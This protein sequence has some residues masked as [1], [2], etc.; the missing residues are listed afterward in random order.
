MKRNADPVDAFIKAA[1]LKH[2]L[3][4]RGVSVRQLRAAS[5]KMT[6]AFGRIV[7]EGPALQARLLELA[8]DADPVIAFAAALRSLKFDTERSTRALQ[9]LTL[10]DPRVAGKAANAL[11]MWERGDWRLDEGMID[12]SGATITYPPPL[13]HDSPPNPAA[14]RA[15]LVAYANRDDPAADVFRAMLAR[16][17]AKDAILRRMAASGDED[18]KD[19]ADDSR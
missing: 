11:G 18:S 8:D 10:D 16:A 7:R 13:V 9:R 19:G 17:D 4:K 12:S 2:D 1:R 6:D 14:L 5:A 15:M 3:D